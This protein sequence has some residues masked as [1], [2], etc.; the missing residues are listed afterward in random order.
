MTNV[1]KV[2]LEAASPAPHHSH[3]LPQRRPPQTM[4]NS[5][6]NNGKGPPYSS[7]RDYSDSDTDDGQDD[8]IQAEIRQQRVSRL[9]LSSVCCARSKFVPFFYRFCNDDY[10]F[11]I[12]PLPCLVFSCHGVYFLYQLHV[13][14]ICRRHYCI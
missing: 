11:K 3:N 7:I 6:R 10:H 8:F 2:N 9:C 4:F 12:R 13:F 1:Q 14:S 5:N